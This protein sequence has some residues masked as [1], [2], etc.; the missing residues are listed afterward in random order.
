M[1]ILLNGAFGIGKTTVARML[2]PRLPRAVLFNPE[3]IGSALQRSLRLVG[4]DV[5]DFQDLPSWRRWTIAGLRTTRKFFTNIVVPMAFSNVEY[6]EQI[7]RGIRR[8]EPDVPH[9]CL[10]APVEVV[11]DRIRRRGGEPWAYKRASECCMAHESEAFAIR[12]DAGDRTPDDIVEELFRRIQSPAS[13]QSD[14][15]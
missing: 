7:R 10:V 9:F 15:A 5:Y 3:L 6:L 14:C 8:F 1:I 11:H 2:V 4:R 12:V 13:A